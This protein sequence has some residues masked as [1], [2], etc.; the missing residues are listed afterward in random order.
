MLL[1]C[2]LTCTVFVFNVLWRFVSLLCWFPFVS[3]LLS[4]A[5]CHTY[6]FVSSV[7]IVSWT[8]SSTAY[9]VCVC[10]LSCRYW[11]WCCVW[12]F[13]WFLLSLFL[14]IWQYGRVKALGHLSNSG[15]FL[16]QNLIYNSLVSLMYPKTP[17]DVAKSMPWKSF[18]LFCS[19]STISQ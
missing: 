8:H 7:N 17:F 6:R 15:F 13:V 18:F 9:N 11:F 16:S 2:F 14:L 4:L 5:V 12:F 3:V 19:L 1:F 10:I